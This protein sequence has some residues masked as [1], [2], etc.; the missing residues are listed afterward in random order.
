[1][2]IRHKIAQPPGEKKVSRLR[3]VQVKMSENDDVRRNEKQREA[4]R[5]RKN[6]PQRKRAIPDIAAESNNFQSERIAGWRSKFLIFPSN[7]FKRGGVAASP[8]GKESSI[9]S[10]IHPKEERIQVV[11]AKAYQIEEEIQSEVAVDSTPV[12]LSLFTA[13]AHPKTDNE[14]GIGEG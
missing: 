1:M 3:P 14:R 2:R 10:K 9:N 7:A 12:S 6:V 13:V 8:D 11:V 4:L 5:N